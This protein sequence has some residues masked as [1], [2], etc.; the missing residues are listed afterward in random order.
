MSEED[1]VLFEI[2]DGVG[3]VTLNRPDRMNAVHWDM[4]EQLVS[5]AGR[6]IDLRRLPEGRVG[7]LDAVADV[8]AVGDYQ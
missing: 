7:E 2:E 8:G 1:H 4:A 5:L 3:V 6:R